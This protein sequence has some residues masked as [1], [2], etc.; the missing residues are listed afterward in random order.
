MPLTPD[1]QRVEDLYDSRLQNHLVTG[2]LAGAGGMG[3][4]HVLRKARQKA[5]KLKKPEPNYSALASA[6]FI[7]EKFATQKSAL[8][9]DAAAAVGMPILGAGAGALYNLYNAKKGKK[10]RSALEGAGI[11]GGIGALGTLLGTQHGAR[12]LGA[13]LRALENAPTISG[14]SEPLPQGRGP[15]SEA[16]QQTGRILAPAAGVAAGGYAVHRLLD[17]EGDHERE[18]VDKIQ[19][20]RKEYFD[21]LMTDEKS[22]SLL[23]KA[24]AVYK[25]GCDKQANDPNP[26]ASKLIWPFG[27]ISDAFGDAASVALTGTILASLGAAGVGGTYMYNKTKAK[28]DAKQL[29]QARLAKE[30]MSS[31][32]GPWIDPREVA[33]VKALAMGN[34][35]ANNA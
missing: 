20:A 13:P 5:E 2:L 21:S 31:L 24:F 11:G 27:P 8:D 10:L 15:L 6:P 4:F 1:Q 9:W 30:R 22:A 16:L 34:P 18:N 29:Q 19:Q 26:N 23:D 17:E 7:P 35:T 3:L 25:T 12:M 28:S 14:S 32:P 33:H